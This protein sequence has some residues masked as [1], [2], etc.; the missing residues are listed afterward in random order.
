MPNKKKQTTPKKSAKKAIPKRK[1]ARKRVAF[2]RS[3]LARNKKFSAK[4]KKVTSTGLVVETVPL[5]SEEWREHRDGQ[6]GDLQGLSNRPTANSESVEELL[7]EGNALEGEAIQGVENAL[8]A[9][10][11]EVQTHEVPEEDVPQEYLDKD[12]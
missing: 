5:P 6:A 4:G 2:K 1:V 10:Q 12:R 9:D 3:S 7:D 11:G 8:D